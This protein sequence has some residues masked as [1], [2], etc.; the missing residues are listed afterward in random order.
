MKKITENKAKY[1]NYAS[2]VFKTVTNYY[3][4][5]Y[6]KV[7]LLKENKATSSLD[8]I[9]D[10]YFNDVKKGFKKYSY[11]GFIIDNNETNIFGT[12]AIDVDTIYQDAEFISMYYRTLEEL[13]F[14]DL[15]VNIKVNNSYDITKLQNYLEYLE[16]DYETNETSNNILEF[17]ITYDDTL[18]SAGIKT[19]NKDI[20]Y[21]E[22]YV[23]IDDLVNLLSEEKEIA[24]EAQIYIVADTEEERITAMRLAQD[25]RWCEIKTFVDTINLSRDKQLAIAEENNASKIVLINADDLNKGLIAVRDNYLKEDT[26]VDENEIID[27]IVSNL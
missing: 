27:Y 20:T 19:I 7:P 14:E 12:L 25:L 8:I 15:A 22:G 16:V 13:G 6:L 26:K 17:T 21:I 4:Y 3:N 5:D 1:Y 18:L 23:N 2:S 11:E 24:K 9:K 10:Y